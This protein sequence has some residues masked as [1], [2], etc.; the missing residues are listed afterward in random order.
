MFS[1]GLQRGEEEV[2]PLDL[3]KLP[4]ESFA[5]A[6]MP[7]HT[8]EYVHQM[9]QVGGVPVAVRGCS[10]TSPCRDALV[11]VSP[12]GLGEGHRPGWLVLAG[13]E[14]VGKTAG[15]CLLSRSRGT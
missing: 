9:R 6:E 12:F 15:T 14:A 1:L 13:R 10:S 7:C 4:L 8:S 11:E 3:Q 5:G 2:L